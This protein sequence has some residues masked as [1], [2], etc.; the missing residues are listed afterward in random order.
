M[1][2]ITSICY[3]IT[4][5]LISLLISSCSAVEGIF[6]AGMDFGIFI[7]IAVILI[8]VVVVVRIRKK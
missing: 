1:V 3:L 2:K 8:I 6:K 5:A 7:V 4:L